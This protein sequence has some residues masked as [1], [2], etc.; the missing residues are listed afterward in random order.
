[1][2]PL[3]NQLHKLVSEVEKRFLEG[4]NLEKMIKE[5]IQI[6]KSF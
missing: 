4:D 5:N 1:M 3:L 6:V 2:L